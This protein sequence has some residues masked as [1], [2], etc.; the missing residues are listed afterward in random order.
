MYRYSFVQ[1]P[2]FRCIFRFWHLH[3][4]LH[5]NPTDDQAKASLKHQIVDGHKP[6]ASLSCGS[7]II[8][9]TAEP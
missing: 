2:C 7:A 1:L 4:V 6:L 5:K 9:W 3:T 8:A